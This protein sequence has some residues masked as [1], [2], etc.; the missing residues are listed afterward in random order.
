[1]TGS[2]RIQPQPQTDVLDLVFRLGVKEFIETT[3]EVMPKMTALL[4]I[5]STLYDMTKETINHEGTLESLEVAIRERTDPIQDKI[6]DG[7]SLVEE[8]RD[9]AEENTSNVGVLLY[10]KCLKTP[11]YRKIFDL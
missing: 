6:E 8:A 5:M 3:I 9:R 2:A 7:I 11:R 10:T 1:M 4:K